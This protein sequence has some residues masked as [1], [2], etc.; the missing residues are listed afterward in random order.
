VK[1][2]FLRELAF[3]AA[4]LLLL[5]RFKDLKAQALAVLFSVLLFVA[6]SKTLSA[7]VLYPIDW[8]AWVGVGLGAVVSASLPV[9]VIALLM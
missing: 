1:T 9:L 8:E 7:F 4:P 5:T 3:L 6:L 2:F